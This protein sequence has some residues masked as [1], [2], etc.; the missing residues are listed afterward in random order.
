MFDYV[1]IGAGSAGCVMANRLSADDSKR[2]L[3]IESGSKDWHPYIKI[4]AAFFHLFETKYDWAY[5]S[6]PQQ[7]LNGRRLFMPRGK[8][9]GGSS[10]INAMIYI[11]GHKEDFDEWEREGCKGWGYQDVLPY[12]LKSEN[13]QRFSNYYHS[14][15]GELFVSD[16]INANSLT[17]IFIQAC[18]TQ[19]IRF[20][21]DFNGEEQE[22]CGYFQT[23][24]INGR[25]WSS[26][27]AFLKP[28]IKRKNLQI[29]SKAY[30]TRIHFSGGKA[31]SIDYIQG[32]ESKSLSIS[33]KLILCGGAINTPQLLLLSGIGP[34]NELQEM[35]IPVIKDLPVG[36]NLQDHPVVPF[37]FSCTQN[38]TLDT[39]ETIWNIL[40]YLFTKKGPFT[41]NIA[42][43][44]GFFKSN[45]H[46]HA[47]DLQLHFVPAF[48]ID[49]GRTRPKGNGFSV[50][51]I[52]VK[53]QSRGSIKLSSLNPMDQ[54]IIDQKFFSEPEDMQA[55]I[56]GCKKTIDILLSKPFAP[57]RKNWFLPDRL[58]KTDEELES[59]I[60]QTVEALYHPVGTC[61]MGTDITCVTNPDLSLK[62]FD[63]VFIADASVMPSITRGNTNAP[64]YMIAEKGANMILNSN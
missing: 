50:A 8:V 10:S 6:S 30:V 33:N 37:I 41:S 19:G 36:K 61:K 34:G 55:L 60:R 35:G 2:V 13:N 4:P 17:D 31:I 53:P 43:A 45:P 16:P 42:E 40:K 58:L 57:F 26:A 63:N 56:A 12:F 25:R 1:I 15:Q 21:E 5:Y 38:I 46:L 23:N 62:G 11:R 39:Q 7:A 59:H 27:D 3:L 29:I 9:W 14:Q 47:P 44:G 52:L 32:N 51:P 64:T 22:G 28:V 48:F 49:H 18:E 54:P 20:I 24:T